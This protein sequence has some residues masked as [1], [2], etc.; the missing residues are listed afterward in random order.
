M[1]CPMKKRLLTVRAN[2]S[3]TV[4]SSEHDTHVLEYLMD[5]VEDP[6]RCCNSSRD[7]E[8]SAGTRGSVMMMQHRIGNTE[9]TSEWRDAV[10][11]P[12]V[13][14]GGYDELR[15]VRLRKSKEKKL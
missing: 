2:C 7:T 9:V 12:S 11:R 14:V 13:P 8:T 6:H 4:L 5:V 3:D 1:G 10:D 15:K